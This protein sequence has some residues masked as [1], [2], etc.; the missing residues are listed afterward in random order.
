MVT[1]SENA[2]G[3]GKNSEDEKNTYTLLYKTDDYQEPT[4]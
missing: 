1:I 4:V 3:G 2:G